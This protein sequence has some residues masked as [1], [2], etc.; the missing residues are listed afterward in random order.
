MFDILNATSSEIDIDHK[1]LYAFIPEIVITFKV[2]YQRES[3][4]PAGKKAGM[5]NFCVRGAKW[6]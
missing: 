2:F 6:M 3:T 5:R 4:K 1:I